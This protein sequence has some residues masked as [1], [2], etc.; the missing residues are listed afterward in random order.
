MWCG[1]DPSLAPA[2]SDS[3]TPTSFYDVIGD[4]HDAAV[5]NEPLAVWPESDIPAILGLEVG[6][7]LHFKYDVLDTTYALV[8][9][10]AASE[11]LG[12]QFVETGDVVEG[13]V[14]PEIKGL[15]TS[16]V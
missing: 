16:H 14:P 8:A 5:C 13:T 11:A 7:A 10:Y 12:S 6:V 2:R 4:S 1:V 15:T 3:S 9:P